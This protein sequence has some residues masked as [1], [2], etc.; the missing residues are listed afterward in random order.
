MQLFVVSLVL[1]LCAIYTA[2]RLWRRF[3]A[4]PAGDVGC[5]GCPL[6]ESCSHRGGKGFKGSRVQGLRVQGSGFRVKRESLP[7]SFGGQGC[8][9]INFLM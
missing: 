6:A 2:R 4:P 1:V 9:H 8:F 3:T 5:E 7:G